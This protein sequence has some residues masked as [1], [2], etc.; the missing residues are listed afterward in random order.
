M[1]AK[2]L[3]VPSLANKVHKL[4][5]LAIETPQAFHDSKWYE[6]SGQWCDELDKGFALPSGTVAGFVAALSPLNSWPSQLKYTPPSLQNGLELIA[7]GDAPHSGISGP[8]FFANKDKAARILQGEAPLD[9]LGGDKVRSFFRNLTGCG[10]AVT[11]D[12]HA[13]AIVGL[14]ETCTPK[15]YAQVSKAY[16]IAGAR[17]GLTGAETQ[18]LTWNYW[19]RNHT[20]QRLDK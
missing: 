3:N 13:L 20:V 5:L 16:V 1:K 18:A 12:R 19:R 2:K 15:Q 6:Y 10:E 8:G 4:A 9:V 11:I 14:G 7:S 17:L